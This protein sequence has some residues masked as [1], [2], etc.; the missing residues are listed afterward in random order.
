MENRHDLMGGKKDEKDAL[1]DLETHRQYLIDK[2]NY[3]NE[4]NWVASVASMNRISL[5][6]VLFYNEIINNIIDIPGVITEL[7]VQWGATTSLLYNLTSIHEPFNFRRRIVGFDTFSGFPSSSISSDEK[8]EGW[9]VNDLSTVDNIQEVVD[10]CLTSHQA[11]SAMKHMD[12]HEFVRGDVVKTLPA[13][14]EK[15]EHETIAMCIFDMD[16]G[17]P[18]S[19]ALKSIMPRCQKGTILVFDEY[20]HPRFREEGVAARKHLDTMKIKPIKSALLPYTSYVI[21]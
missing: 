19:E 16:L 15:N 18:T 12:R 10:K 17:I 9:K 5:S 3:Q 7:G 13:W 1:I 21:L 8:K 14:L 4:L 11:F 20:S 6:K 2:C